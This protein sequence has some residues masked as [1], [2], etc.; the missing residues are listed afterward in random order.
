M[1][2]SSLGRER[3]PLHRVFV[4]A[5]HPEVHVLFCIDQE[6]RPLEHF[7]KDTLPTK[8]AGSSTSGSYMLSAT[9]RGSF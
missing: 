1:R 3:D 2:Y 6:T 8:A 7:S 4:D 9:A 5:G